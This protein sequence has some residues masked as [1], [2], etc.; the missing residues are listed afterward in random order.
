MLTKQPSMKPLPKSRV[1][2]TMANIML[3]TSKIPEIRKEPVAAPSIGEKKEIKTNPKGA[4]PKTKP[5]Q[6][7]LNFLTGD[8]SMG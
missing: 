3:G 6:T 7:V 5:T 1:L 2:G 8:S 4:T